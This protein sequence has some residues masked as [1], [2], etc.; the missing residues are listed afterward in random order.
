MHPSQSSGLRFPFEM[1][2]LWSTEPLG[3]RASRG[4]SSLANWPT[5]QPVN[6]Y[7][8]P[9]PLPLYA[10]LHFYLSALASPYA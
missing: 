7:V 2:A 8:L 4:C 9:R 6:L 1:S 3:L 5:G 10:H